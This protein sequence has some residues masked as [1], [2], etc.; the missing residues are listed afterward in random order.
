MI[1]PTTKV[2]YSIKEVSELLHVP[3]PTL[4]FWERE[5]QQ[6]QPRTNAGHTRF[7]SEK[8]IQI[9]RRLIYF[10][11][12]NIPVKEWS[13]RLKLNDNQLDRKVQARENLLDVRAELEALLKL[14]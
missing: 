10:R 4:R 8:D 12:Q 5:V 13:D 3:L 9:L 2:Y 1:A 7:Y 11:S 14:L 6:L